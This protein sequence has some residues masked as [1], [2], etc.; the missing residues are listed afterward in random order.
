MDPNQPQ[1]PFESQPVQPEAPLSVDYLNQIAP[2][3]PKR[4][5]P[6]TRKQMIVA[7]I[8]GGAF[9]IVMILVIAV[10]LGGGG[11][12][13]QLEQLAARLQSTQT[14]VTAADSELNDSQL[15]ALNSN[16]NIYLT[17]TNRDIAAPLLKDGIDVTK[18][19]SSI[20]ASE[21]GAD[22]TARLEDAR[23]NAVYDSTYARE[24]AYRLATIVSLMRQ[25]NSSTSNQDLKTFLA[26]AY[27]NLQ[28]TQ[29][30]FEDFDAAN[31]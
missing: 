23:L 6:L 22:V 11:T 26:G 17:N 20:V 27:T 13:K 12:K 25:I 31:G 4:K 10:G 3:A 5:I 14:I 19:D 24:I 30:A 29:K 15:R 9:I 8:L 2:Q 1:P 21:S 7:G 18:L 16:L 28:P